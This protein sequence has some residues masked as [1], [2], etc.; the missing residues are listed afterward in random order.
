MRQL[1][2]WKLAM[3]LQVDIICE[4]THFLYDEHVWKLF[5]YLDLYLHFYLLFFGLRRCKYSHLFIE[6]R[7]NEERNK[8]IEDAL[9]KSDSDSL[10]WAVSVAMLASVAI[11]ETLP[12]FNRIL[13][14]TTSFIWCQSS[15]TSINIQIK[16]FHLS[17]FDH[18]TTSPFPLQKNSK[19][20][21]TLDSVSENVSFKQNFKCLDYPNWIFIFYEEFNFSLLS[22]LC[23]VKQKKMF[24]LL[25]FP[26]K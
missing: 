17:T 25:N 13:S 12:T 8:W 7:E 2:S 6:K 16:T 14:I 18:W 1:Q 22:T 19:I 21:P 11:L 10:G 26:S 3:Q 20:L 9:T 4:R 15:K 23:I 24:F 5:H